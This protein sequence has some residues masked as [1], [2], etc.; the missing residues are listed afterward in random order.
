MLE[1]A[2][3]AIF[4]AETRALAVGANSLARVLNLNSNRLNTSI[5]NDFE[6]R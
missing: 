3:K 5:G 4:F 1:G 6:V 2:Q